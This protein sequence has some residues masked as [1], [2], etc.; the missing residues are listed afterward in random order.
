MTMDVNT[1]DTSCD[2]S[3]IVY[4]SVEMWIHRCWLRS[5]LLKGGVHLLRVIQDSS[6]CHLDVRGR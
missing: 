4:R 5:S 1:T 6:V 3:V 2:L